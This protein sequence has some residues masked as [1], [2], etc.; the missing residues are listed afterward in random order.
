[1]VVSCDTQEEM[2][3][4]AEA[5]EGQLTTTIMG[6]DEEISKQKTLIEVIREKAGR[7][8]FNGVPTGVEVGY[9]MHHGGPYPSASSSMYT[10]V[11]TDAILRFVRPM[12]FQNA[13]QAILPDALKDGNPLNIWRIVNGKTVK[14]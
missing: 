6:S 3:A 2:I 13:P 9:A 4:V 10:S 7:L 14:A 5:L 11:G 8:I 1:M 12:C